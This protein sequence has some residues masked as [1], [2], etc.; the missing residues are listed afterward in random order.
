M[1]EGNIQSSH[2]NSCRRHTKHD[3]LNRHVVDDSYV[4]EHGVEVSKFTYTF[5]ACRGCSTASLMVNYFDNLVGEYEPVLYPART[6]RRLPQWSCQL[7]RE[8]RELLQE[9]YSTLDAGSRRL[10]VMG[11]R[12]LLDL[13]LTATVGND[14]YFV[15]RLEKL[16]RVGELAPLDKGTLR[17]ALE[18]GNAAAHRGY[19]PAVTDLNIVMDIVENLLQKHVLQSTAKRLEKT[20]PPRT[21]KSQGQLG[22]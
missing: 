6:F 13:Y 10:A 1:S 3:V 9:I 8:W 4:D 21:Q 16:V 20:T 2:C 17:A 15:E 12:T 14:G 19:N 11:A 18:A 5:L 7:N 22:Q